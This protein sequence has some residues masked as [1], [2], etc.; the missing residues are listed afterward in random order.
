MLYIFTVSFILRGPGH[1]YTGATKI[2]LVFANSGVY[3]AK[4]S[5]KYCFRQKKMSLRR[6]SFHS[7]MLYVQHV[8]ILRQ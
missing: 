6:L 7:C 3:V 2:S 5:G 8:N 1:F 4:G